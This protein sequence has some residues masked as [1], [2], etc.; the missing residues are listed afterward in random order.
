MRAGPAIVP[1]RRGGDRFRHRLVLRALRLVVAVDRRALRRGVGRALTCS[2]DARPSRPRT[3]RS[4]R[5]WGTGDRSRSARVRR[6]AAP[7]A[8][9]FRVL[10][11]SDAILSRHVGR[12]HRPANGPW[13]SR[14]AIDSR[15]RSAT[16]DGRLEKLLF[17]VLSAQ[18]GVERRLHVTLEHLERHRHGPFRRRAAPRASADSRRCVFGS[19]CC[20]PTST[21][22]TRASVREHRLEVGEVPLRVSNTRSGTYVG[23][24]SRR[25]GRGGS[26]RS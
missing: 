8:T 12:D 17:G 2:Q 10:A 16:R 6:S 11:I 25:P 3:D 23:G 13:R 22:S 20:S 4:R 15:S 5:P 7:T 18:I 14:R 26:W 1:R 21:T 19:S 24:C 9:R